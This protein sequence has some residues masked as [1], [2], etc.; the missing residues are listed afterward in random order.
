MS[1][2]F[3]KP[4]P[5]RHIKPQNTMCDLNNAHRDSSSDKS[6]THNHDSDAESEHYDGPAEYS[7]CTPFFFFTSLE[8]DSPLF[9]SSRVKGIWKEYPGQCRLSNYWSLQEDRKNG[10]PP[11]SNMSQIRYPTCTKCGTKRG[12]ARGIF[13][14]PNLTLF[15]C[16]MRL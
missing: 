13:H 1:L 16:L 4:A 8:T 6:P 15:P 3:R 7:T 11:R 9:P 12:G 5:P 2:T 14:W 10:R